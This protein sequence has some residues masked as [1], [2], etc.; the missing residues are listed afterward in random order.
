MWV[1]LETCTDRNPTTSNEARTP[2]H[3]QLTHCCRRGRAV[4]QQQEHSN[5]NAASRAGQE[6][7]GPHMHPHVT[8]HEIV[9]AELANAADRTLFHEPNNKSGHITCL[10][11]K[12]Q[13]L[14]QH[15]PLQRTTQTRTGG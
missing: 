15:L 2:V 6:G 11:R 9:H 5:R 4:V 7:R 8:L 1:A 3:S 10:T 14:T 12:Q 13:Q